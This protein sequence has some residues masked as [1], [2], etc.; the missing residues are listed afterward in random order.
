MYIHVGGEYSL[1]D[2]FIVGIFDIDSTTVQPSDTIE[3]LR[4]KEQAGLLDVVSPE[5]PRSFI[6]TLDRVY[7]TPISPVTLRRRLTRAR[8]HG[9]SSD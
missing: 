6:V 5:L 9:E 1:S 3:F 4:R 7:V 8:G 2:K